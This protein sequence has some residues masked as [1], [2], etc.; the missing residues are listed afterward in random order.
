MVFFFLLGSMAGQKPDAH[1]L[2]GSQECEV[3][4][5]T[6]SSSYLSSLWPAWTRTH[7]GPRL[8]IQP[9]SALA[10]QEF[11][12]RGCSRDGLELIKSDCMSHEHSYC[13]FKKASSWKLGKPLV[14]RLPAALRGG[15]GSLRSFSTRISSTLAP[16]CLLKPC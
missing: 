8:Q 16:T 11:R 10:K 1:F 2:P 3:S 15:A 6:R 13:P 5:Y 7:E 12:I 4:P 9:S 14:N